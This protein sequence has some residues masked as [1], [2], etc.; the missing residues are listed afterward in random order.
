[1]LDGDYA[2]V[3]LDCPTLKVC[4]PN[5]RP[6]PDC[7]RR[8]TLTLPPYPYLP[9]PPKVYDATDCRIRLL[10]TAFDLVDQV[11]AWPKWFNNSETIEA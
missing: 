11:S 3:V 7:P 6:R 10:D 4:D 2:A 9:P 1:M 8:P 5:D